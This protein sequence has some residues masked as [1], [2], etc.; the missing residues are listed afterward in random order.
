[1]LSSTESK[2]ILPSKLGII[3]TSGS[4]DLLNVKYK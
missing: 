2:K 4:V 3:K 1:M